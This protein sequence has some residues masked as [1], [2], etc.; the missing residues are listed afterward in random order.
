LVYKFY[1]KN[2]VL[3]IELLGF[4]NGIMKQDRQNSSDNKLKGR[5]TAHLVPSVEH[6]A[7]ILMFFGQHHS[8]KANLTEICAA[9]G[10]Y[11]SRGHAILKTLMAYGLVERDEATKRYSL[12]PS[13]VLLS[14]KF[15]KHLDIREKALPFL[16]TL[17][18]ETGCTALLGII[19]EEHLIVIAKRDG[20]THLGITIEV[21]HR[22]HVTAGAHGKAIVSFLHDETAQKVMKQKNLYFYGNS[23]NFDQER[24]AKEIDACRENGYALDMGALQPGIHAAAAPVFAGK[25]NVTGALIVIGTFPKEKASAVGEKIRK[26]AG[27]ISTAMGASMPDIFNVDH[28]AS[29]DD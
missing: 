20:N 16:E 7:R 12:G 11:K 9:L 22:F 2:L 15:L 13:L 1:N 8:S 27:K 25:G 4:I 10:I 6:A 19:S 3:Y 23:E 21:G 26:A 14:R 29:F 24:L 5:D 28:F 17:A 18:R